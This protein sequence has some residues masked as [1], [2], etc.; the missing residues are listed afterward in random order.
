MSFREFD[1]FSRVVWYVQIAC[2]VHHVLLPVFAVISFCFEQW[3]RQFSWWCHVKAKIHRSMR[4]WNISRASFGGHRSWI[5]TCT[6]DEQF[7]IRI[8]KIPMKISLK[9]YPDFVYRC[10]VAVPDCFVC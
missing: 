3:L 9:T 7:L 1:E 5:G 2:M 10:R 6:N 4:Q 8:E